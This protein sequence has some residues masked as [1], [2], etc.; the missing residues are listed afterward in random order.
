MDV[1]FVIGLAIEVAGA[2]L[3]AAGQI[4]LVDR[5]IATRGLSPDRALAPRREVQQ[6]AARFTV[7]FALLAV[8]VVVQVFGYAIDGGW[9]L[10]GLAVGVTALAAAVG[11]VIADDPVT[12]W[13]HKQA[14]DYWQAAASDED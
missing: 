4:K 5:V 10:L 12:S 14:V 6:E 13:L 8:G 7:G 2:A 3:L 1:V 9:W 11:R